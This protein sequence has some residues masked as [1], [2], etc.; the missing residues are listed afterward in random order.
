MTERQEAQERRAWKTI[1]EAYYTPRDERT[2]EQHRLT[3]SGICAAVEI[4]SWDLG[5]IAWF[6]ERSMK[7]TIEDSRINGRAWFCATTW[8]PSFIALYDL[9]RADYCML[10]YYILGGE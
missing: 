9:L 4:L 8:M 5:H 1:A 6:V 2:K 7:D 3:R 10:Q